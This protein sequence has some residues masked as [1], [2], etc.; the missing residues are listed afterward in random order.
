MSQVARPGYRS[1]WFH[2]S[3]VSSR[4]TDKARVEFANRAHAA[5]LHGGPRLGAQKIQH[6]RDT[7]LAEGSEPPEIGP[8]DADRLGA[9]RE[10]LDGIRAATESTVDD[11]GNLPLHRGDD[12][13]QHVD[14]GTAIVLA[15]AAVI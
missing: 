10:R 15:A 8:S 13:R 5:L 1:V 3:A 7:F 4:P 2:A 14:R 6:T 11:D 12:F 9:H